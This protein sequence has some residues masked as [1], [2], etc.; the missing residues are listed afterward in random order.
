MPCFVDIMRPLTPAET[1][2][3]GFYLRLDRTQW[4]HARVLFRRAC[5]GVEPGSNLRR[6]VAQTGLVE[7]VVTVHLEEILRDLAAEVKR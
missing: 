7:A 3:W 4:R 2:A 6:F 5:Q 1:A